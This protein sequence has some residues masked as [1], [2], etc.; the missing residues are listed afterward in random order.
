MPDTTAR[1]A[2]IKG[3]RELATFL[4]ANR[5]VPV[6]S[7]AGL[8][9]FPEGTDLDIRAEV[10]AIAALLG[11]QADPGDSEHAHYRACRTFGPVEY[12]AVGI[13]AA[14]RARHR[15]NTS[16]EGCITPDPVPSSRTA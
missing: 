14:S 1:A 3:L 4:E 9:Y 11:T 16:Y 10:D 7:F 5:A 15:A 6:P 12:T 8:T 2:L 13:F